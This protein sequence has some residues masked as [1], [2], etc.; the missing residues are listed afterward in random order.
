MFHKHANLAEA[1]RRRDCGFCNGQMEKGDLVLHEW[2]GSTKRIWCLSCA[3][4]RMAAM[5]KGIEQLRLE[6]GLEL[7]KNPDK[8][9]R[10]TLTAK[11]KR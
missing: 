9:V 1:V 8:Y 10:T 5:E 3:L 7:K 11:E 4:I 6:I 2:A